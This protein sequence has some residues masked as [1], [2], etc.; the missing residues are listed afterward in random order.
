M[1]ASKKIGIAI[2][3]AF[4]PINDRHICPREKGNLP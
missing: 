2:G 4:D 1:Q 3:I